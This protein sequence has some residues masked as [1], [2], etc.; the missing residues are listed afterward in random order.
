MDP[1]YIIGGSLADPWWTF[2]RFPADLMHLYTVQTLHV[3]L[4]QGEVIVDVQ[5]IDGSQVGDPV[6]KLQ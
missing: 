4:G 2:R 3:D 1:H 5:C 6:F